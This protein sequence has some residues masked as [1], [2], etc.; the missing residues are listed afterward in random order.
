MMFYHADPEPIDRKKFAL[1][2]SKTWRL[3][4]FLAAAK[5]YRTPNTQSNRAT[6]PPAERRRPGFVFHFVTLL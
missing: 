2:A 4:F 5:I 1:R 6:L 3:I